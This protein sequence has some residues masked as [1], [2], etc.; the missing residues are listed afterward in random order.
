VLYL[1]KDDQG[2]A[3]LI[4]QTSEKAEA[5]T[6]G[7]NHLPEFCGDSEEIDPDS[8]AEA[9]EF[10]GVRTVRLVNV[11][12]DPDAQRRPGKAP[13]ATV[14]HLWVRGPRLPDDVE[15]DD[16]LTPED[17]RDLTLDHIA[18]TSQLVGRI[19]IMKWA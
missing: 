1:L 14:T 5:D 18:R 12:L 13:R 8:R 19:Q 17:R 7:R 9:E 2:R 16:L 15:E 3:L 10:W 11:V 6:F 4:A